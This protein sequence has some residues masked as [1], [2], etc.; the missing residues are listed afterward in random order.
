MN[1]PLP[2]RIGILI[3][4][5]LGY[6]KIYESAGIMMVFADDAAQA[7]EWAAWLKTVGGIQVERCGTQLTLQAL[8]EAGHGRS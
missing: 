4:Q 5:H 3:R 6:R 8:R 1:G 2:F 7:S